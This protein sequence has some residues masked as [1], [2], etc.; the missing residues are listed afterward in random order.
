MGNSY[1][2]LLAIRYASENP[3]IK[4]VITD[5][6]FSSLDDTVATSVRY[7]TG[8][9]PFPFAPMIL[10]WGEREAGFQASQV[11]A[12]LWIRSISPRPIL[13]M[14]GGA[15]IIIS[16]DSG[17]KLYAAAGEPKELWYDPEVAHAQFDTQRAA[18]FER[19]VISFYDRWLLEK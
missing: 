16:K 14:Q 5:S 19:R 13:L 17:Q 2:G 15:D 18:E 8:L 9:P 12:T 1:G 3:A 10:F 6:A 7:F 11:D 4:A